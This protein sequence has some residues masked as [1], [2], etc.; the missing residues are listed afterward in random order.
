MLIN[1]ACVDYGSEYCPCIMAETGHCVVC[2]R[3]NGSDSC[4]CR[5]YDGGV[6]VLEELERN[7]GKAKPFR[8][9]YTCSVLTLKKH[10][11]FVFMRLNVPSN[12]EY[13][14]KTIG[15]FVF[16][17]TNENIWFDTPISIQYDECFVGSI[18]V[19]VLTCGIKTS[20]FANLKEGDTV[21]LRGPFF[22]GILGKRE[23][24]SQQNGKC[25]VFAKGVAL[26]PSISAINYLKNQGNNVKIFVDKSS[27]SKEYL[28]FHLE[29]FELDYEPI[30]LVDKY[31]NL[32]EIA[33][34]TILDFVDNG[35]EL[36][37]IGTSEYVIHLIIDYLN[38]IHAKHIRL[39]CCNNEKM[40]C[41]EGVCGACTSKSTNNKT[42]HSCKEQINIWEK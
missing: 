27:F 6:C 2:N 23:L 35:G 15:S 30:L 32:T 16:I 21:Y 20:Y 4:D 42:V 31:G 10:E 17:R 9:T 37:H 13:A 25:L 22:S 26:M 28:N 12:F 36:M 8:S 41:G 18:G 33:K 39:S 40:C 1:S 38:S 11:S 34:N 5:I 3:V 19:Y 14:V 29:L 7:N 24:Q